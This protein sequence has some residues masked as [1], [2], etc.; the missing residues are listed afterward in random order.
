MV[1]TA[2]IT[3]GASGI[4]LGMARAF[5]QAGMQVVIG[6]VD[7]AAIAGAVAGLAAEGLHIHGERLDVTKAASWKTALDRIEAAMGPVDLLCNNAGVGQG[8]FADGAPIGLADMPE[9]LWR[10]VMEANAT[11]RGRVRRRPEP[12]MIRTPG[13]RSPASG[14][15]VWNI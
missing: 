11:D 5:A 2:L 6:D 15:W 12:G 3:G 7:E 13:G 1:Q 14:G 10:L 9:R 8:R 4:G